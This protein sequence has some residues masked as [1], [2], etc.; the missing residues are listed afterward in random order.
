MNVER[1]FKLGAASL[2]LTISTQVL[3]AATPEQIAKLG[4]DELT[5][6]G[7]ERA[8]KW[9]KTWPGQTKKSG[10][11][12]GPYKDEKPLFTITAQNMSEHSDKM[13]PGQIALMQK[14]PDAFK[15]KIFES[16]RDFKFADWVCDVV[17]KNGQNAEV[18]NDGLGVTGVSEEWH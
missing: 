8:G 5:C 7:A 6:R 10:W 17:K 1:I 4:G 12:P 2:A 3:A 14:Y 9:F 13:T 11:E 16:H 18:I 15:M